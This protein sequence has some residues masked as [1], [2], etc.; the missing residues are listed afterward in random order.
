MDELIAIAI[1]VVGL[2][3]WAAASGTR[4]L[5]IAYPEPAENPLRIAGWF[6]AKYSWTSMSGF[7]KILAN[8]DG[9][10]LH[11]IWPIWF[12]PIFVPWRDVSIRDDQNAASSTLELEFQQCPGLLISV[13]ASLVERVQDTI[14]SRIP[15]ECFAGPSEP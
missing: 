13:G 1:F 14:E 7:L 3:G 12:H 6:T 8:K 15:G 4:K 2:L 11:S 10:A 5:S 9:L